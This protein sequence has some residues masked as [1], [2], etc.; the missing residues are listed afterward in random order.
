MHV[1]VRGHAAPRRAFTPI[2]HPREIC[3][4]D[5]R[6]VSRHIRTPGDTLWSTCSAAQ[7]LTK[8]ELPFALILLPSPLSAL[9]AHCVPCHRCLAA[10]C[11]SRTSLDRSRAEAVN[12][13]FGSGKAGAAAAAARRRGRRAVLADLVKTAAA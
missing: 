10:V 5:E 4:E 13:R 11:K 6:S 3:P 8:S 2:S 7:E 9:T 1:Q 12:L